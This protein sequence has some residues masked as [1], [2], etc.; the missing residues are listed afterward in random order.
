MVIMKYSVIFDL[1]KQIANIL[2]ALQIIDPSAVLCDDSPHFQL[3]IDR[4]ADDTIR[5]N[6]S[7]RTPYI[8]MLDFP[9]GTDPS[10]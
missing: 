7:I 8:G 10:G 4:K 6:G 3:Q 1:P 9:M 2:A 5:W